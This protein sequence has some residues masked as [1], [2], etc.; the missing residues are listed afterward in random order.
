MLDDL[1]HRLRELDIMAGVRRPSMWQHTSSTGSLGSI[2]SSQYQSPPHDSAQGQ[3]VYSSP[4]NSAQGRPLYQSPHN[5]AQGPQFYQ[6]TAPAVQP[7]QSHTGYNEP[8]AHVSPPPHQH[9]PSIAGLYGQPG[10]YPPSLQ[11]PQ[12]VHPAQSQP[13]QFN[14]QFSFN[15]PS[16]APRQ[17]LPPQFSAPSQQFASWGGYSRASMPD[18]LD[19]ENAVPPNSNPWDYD[20][21]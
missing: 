6:Q 9:R 13:P 20:K 3:P 18:T 11:Q 19:E 2:H 4:H 5:S 12:F 7:M 8:L 17:Q 15:D 1:S 16:A 14:Q 21:R 10:A